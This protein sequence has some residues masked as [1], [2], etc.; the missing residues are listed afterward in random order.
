MQKGTMEGRATGHTAHGKALQLGP[1]SGQIGTGIVPVHL[2]LHAP[3]VTLRNEGFLNRQAQ[4]QLTRM[5]IAAY[6]AFPDLALRHLASDPLPNPMRLVALLAR[7][8]LVTLQYLIDERCGRRQFPSWPLH[9]LPRCRQGA[10]NRL[11]HHTSMYV[12]LIADT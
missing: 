11:A 7:R 5:H 9:F 4:R 2:G 12:N 1:F 8:F 3:A 6:R 10:A